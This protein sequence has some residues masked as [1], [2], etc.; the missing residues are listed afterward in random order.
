M[1]RRTGSPE[2]VPCSIPKRKD[3][4]NMTGLRFGRL[5]IISLAGR[6]ERTDKP[7]A[8]YY[9]WH[10]MCDCGSNSVVSGDSLRLGTTISCGCFRSEYMRE[11]STIH[12]HHLSPEFRIFHGMWHRCHHFG[13]KDWHKYGARGIKVSERWRKFEDFLA[14][15]GHR[16]SPT[17]TIERINNDGDYTPENCRWAT[18]KEQARNRRS[19]RVI[20]FQGQRMC[21]TAWAEILGLK[22][23]TI[24]RRLKHGWQTQEV[25]SQPNRH[26]PRRPRR[27]RQSHC[28]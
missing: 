24:Y 23:A 22:E 7:H 8:Y 9:F 1:P 6:H 17:H 5:L 15:M 10:A 25:L 14:D 4:K 18:P 13:N 16:P 26:R 27:L 12:G 11:R 3:F 28:Q 19:N 2:I 20:E 21:V